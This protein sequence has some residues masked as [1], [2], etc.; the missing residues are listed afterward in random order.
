[1]VVASKML[2]RL[3]AFHHTEA[4]ENTLAVFHYKG[5]NRANTNKEV[6]LQAS[7][8]LSKGCKQGDTDIQPLSAVY[9]ERK[10]R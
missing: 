7:A 8:A 5:L 3:E 4:R 10:R 2:Y 1:M 9:K 6:L